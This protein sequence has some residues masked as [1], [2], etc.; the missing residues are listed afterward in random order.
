MAIDKQDTRTMGFMTVLD[1]DATTKEWVMPTSFPDLSGYREIA[2]DLETH[3]PNLTTLGPGWARKD[4]AARK[5][6]S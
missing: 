5:A 2:I 3:D 4:G 6:K 1:V